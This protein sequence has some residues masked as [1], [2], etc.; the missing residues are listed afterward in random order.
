VEAEL[1]RFCDR[2]GREVGV[3]FRISRQSL[4]KAGAAGIDA[5]QVI[6]L[7]ARRSRSALPSNVLHEIRG[8][9]GECGH[10]PA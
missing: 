8:W 7:L 10:G 6:A 2:V 4:Q 3:L 1:G 9:L 5:E